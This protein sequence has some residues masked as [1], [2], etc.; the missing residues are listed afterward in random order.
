[1]IALGIRNGLQDGANFEAK[2]YMFRPRPFHFRDSPEWW[3]HL[4]DLKQEN[5]HQVGS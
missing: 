4:H 1:M 5:T 3:N 2:T